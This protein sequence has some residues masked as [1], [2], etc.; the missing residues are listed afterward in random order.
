MD[1][2]RKQENLGAAKRE[3]P[4]CQNKLARTWLHNIDTDSTDHTVDK[5]I[6]NQSTTIFTVDC[7]LQD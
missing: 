5:F 6:F 4:K 2:T 7:M 3:I 1:A